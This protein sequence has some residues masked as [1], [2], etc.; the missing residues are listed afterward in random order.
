MDRNDERYSSYVRILRKELICATGCTEPIALAYCAAKAREVLGEIPDKVILT[1]SGNIIKNVKSVVVPNTDG[2]KGLKTAV[3]I[4]IIAGDAS[5]KLEVIN[6][7]KDIDRTKLSDFLNNT[8]FVVKQAK[9]E[10]LLD[11]NVTVSKGKNEAKVR[12]VNQH[13]NIV[14]IEK[15]GIVIKEENE[16]KNNKSEYIDYTKLDIEGICSFVDILDINY[17]KEIIQKQID[18]NTRISEEGMNKEYGSNIGKVIIKSYG[19]DIRNRAKAKAAAGSD[20]RMNGCELPVVI[21]SGSGNQG[22]TVSL[23]VIEYAKELKADKETLF[24]ALVVSNLVAIHIKQGIGPLSAFCGAVSAGVG[25][26]AGIAYLKGGRL[27]EIAHTIVNALAISSGII[28]D[29]AKSSCAAKIAIAVD[30]GIFGYDMYLNNQQ[31]YGGDGLV[32][33]GVENTIKNISHL[34]R[35]GMK[36]TDKEI[37]QLMS[38]VD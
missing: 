6:D 21:N 10:N 7:V 5:K 29:G 27:E 38:C 2:R 20:A 37:I 28:C 18:C 17:V 30:A 9:S 23:P 15:N 35:V 33:K 31:F 4:G 13:T 22:L 8:D 11:I 12:I 34:G 36:E 19:N 32:S 3:A 24:K 14:L 16:S 1:V 26:G 25:A